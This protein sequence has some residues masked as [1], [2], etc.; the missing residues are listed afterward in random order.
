MPLTSS[1]PLYRPA[2]LAIFTLSLHDALPISPPQRPAWECHRRWAA[3][4]GCA[5]HRRNPSG[6]PTRFPA[7]KDPRRSEEHTS[8]L[9]S[10]CKL[11]CR[12]LHEKKKITCRLLLRK[13]TRRSTRIK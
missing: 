13:K 11:V 7:S 10:P 4:R 6:D 5:L 1:S 8:E 9:Q 3:I 2:T 12:L